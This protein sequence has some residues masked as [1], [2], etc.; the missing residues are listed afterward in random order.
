MS[1]IKIIVITFLLCLFIINSICKNDICIN[2]S[3]GFYAD[4]TSLNCQTFYFCF[5]ETLNKTLQCLNSSEPIFSTYRQRCIG[6]N[7]LYDECYLVNIN[8]NHENCAWFSV[9]LS[10]TSNLTYHYS[11]LYPFLF[12]LE[13]KECK[14]YSQVQCNQRFEPKDACDYHHPQ[15]HSSI[16][17]RPCW[18]IPSC[19]NKTNGFH[20]NQ[21]QECS[22]YY[23]C[24]DERFLKLTT[25]PKNMHFSDKSKTCLITLSNCENS[26]KF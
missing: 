15:I 11:C 26:T 14:H 10:T 21:L 18:L 2:K 24:K 20:G 5:N 23:E 13:S 7:P 16:D 17:E 25:C 4:Y 22:S 19:R 12:D 8:E 3:N 1:G 6:V 9:Q